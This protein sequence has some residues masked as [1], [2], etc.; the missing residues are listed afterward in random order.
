MPGCTQRWRRTS[1][2]RRHASAPAECRRDVLQ[3]RLDDV[4]VVLDAELVRHGQKQGIRF[5]DGLSHMLLVALLAKLGRSKEAEAATAR[6][7]ELQPGF[8]YSWQ[9]S[10][11]DRAPALATS[12]GEALRAAGLP[13]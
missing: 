4:G 12:L 2:H 3:N 13:E 11:V 1:K 6:V 9:F 5:R 10:G 7:L 8:R